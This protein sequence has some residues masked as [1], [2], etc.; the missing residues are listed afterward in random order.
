LPLLE[1]KLL[2]LLLP[3]LELRDELPPQL[4]E[5]LEPEPELWLPPKLELCEEEE[6]EE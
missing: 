1:L 6:W 2:L 3:E 5:W 4:E